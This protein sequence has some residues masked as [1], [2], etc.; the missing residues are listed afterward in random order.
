MKLLLVLAPL[1]MTRADFVLVDWA[2]DWYTARDYCR[3]NHVD[4]AS[5][6]S[7]E[8]NTAVTTACADMSSST[9]DCE[10]DNACWIG[11]NDIASEGSWAWSD[12]SSW[13]YENFN[14]GEPNGGSGENLVNI[15]IETTD[16]TYGYGRAGKW[17]D[18]SDGFTAGAFVCTTD[19]ACEGGSECPECGTTDECA[20]EACCHS[21]CCDTYG[22]C[23]NEDDEAGCSY[24][25]VD[26]M[27][28]WGYI[29][30]DWGWYGGVYLQGGSTSLEDCAA[31]VQGYDGQDGCMGEYF[32]YEWE[33]YCN[34]P[35]DSCTAG[36]ETGAVACVLVGVAL[37]ESTQPLAGVA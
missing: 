31:A 37:T 32:F 2:T 28:C 15:W 19:Y 9:G 7:E 18:Y 13:D 5:I 25:E 35:T 11:A 33:G 14:S 4:L 27:G 24:E 30:M 16:C 29:H 21:W 36:Y 10:R 26:G 8:D 22:E 12:G 17:N 3:E 23:C 6:H 1:V 20:A 34:C